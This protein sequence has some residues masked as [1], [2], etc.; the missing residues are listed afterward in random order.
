M[1]YLVWNGILYMLLRQYPILIDSY[2]QVL[3]IIYM[4]NNLF[5]TLSVTVACIYCPWAT[6]L[7]GN[8]G[9]RGGGACAASEAKIHHVPT[10]TT[11]GP[12]TTW[13][14]TPHLLPYDLSLGRDWPFDPSRLA[15]YS[16][17]GAATELVSTLYAY[18]QAYIHIQMHTLSQDAYKTPHYPYIHSLRRESGLERGVR[19]LH[20]V[21]SAS[22]RTWTHTQITARSESPTWNLVCLKILTSGVFKEPFFFC[23]VC[24]CCCYYKCYLCMSLSAHPPAHRIRSDINGMITFLEHLFGWKDNHTKCSFLWILELM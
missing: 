1:L 12:T 2:R 15:N 7:P 24:C 3:F 22:R 11:T 13:P 21:C 9:E 20:T 23:C 4:Y 8:P 18:T 14:L 6:K 19:R 17:T 5:V 10:Q 16:E